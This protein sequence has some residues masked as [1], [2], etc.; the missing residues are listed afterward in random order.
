MG[1]KV[2]L[3]PE[4]PRITV[5]GIRL[6]DPIPD[7]EILIDTKNG[8]WKIGRSIGFGGFGE[9]YLASKHTNNFYGARHDESNSKYVIKVEPHSSSTLFVEMNF[10]LRVATREKGKNCIIFA[11]RNIENNIMCLLCITKSHTVF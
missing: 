7:G 11:R 6:P 9:I 10:Y 1:R 8:Q 2:A 3:T 5:S 4:K